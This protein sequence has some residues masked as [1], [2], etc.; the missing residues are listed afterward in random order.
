MSNDIVEHA[1]KKL[2]AE[3]L[4]LQERIRSLRSSRNALSPI[5]R[6]PPEVM[7][8]IFLWYQLLYRGNIEGSGRCAVSLPKWIRVTHV[9]QHWRNIALTSKTLYSTILT[10]HPQYSNE[11]LNRSGSVALS[12][13]DSVNYGEQQLWDT[14]DLQ[15]LVVAA[16]P[17][18]RSLWLDHKSQEFLV[19]HF[20]TSDLTLELEELDLWEW[21]SFIP[22][23][24]SSSLRHLRLRWCPFRSYEWLIRLS[25]LVELRLLGATEGEV[26]AP[27]TL[28]GMLDGMPRLVYLEL[29]SMLSPHNQENRVSS[30]APKLQYLKLYDAPHQLVGLLSWLSFAPRFQIIVSVKPSDRI[31]W[32]MPF[33]EQIGRHLQQSSM[34]LRSANLTWDDERPYKDGEMLFSEDA[35]EEP[36][37][38][39]EV[40]LKTMALFRTCM[41]SAEALPLD[42]LDSLTADVP[43]DLVDWNH[44]QW[45]SL[46]SLR[47]LVLPKERTSIAYLGYLIAAEEEGQL[48]GEYETFASLEELSLHGL[49]YGRDLKSKMQIV[50]AGRMK[51]G[52]KLR[53]LAFYDCNISEDSI[54]QLSKVVD[55][56][57]RHGKK[58]MKKLSRAT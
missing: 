30:I 7:A 16:L 23:M 24:F 14:P 20:K 54:K 11:M 27:D 52:F 5:H 42:D 32:F 33:F 1:R 45:H 6:L 4:V 49:Q 39:L 46:R 50:L 26:V 56:V 41:K 21:N 55:V 2:D 31:D 29:S 36:C 8:Q 38:R 43:W 57:E 51:R 3:I 37:F 34:K 35:E 58:K 44:G 12:F 28:L 22:S 19:P 40:H 13:I 15:E 47:R 17:R 53:K 48:S 9:S 10:H 18:V 25:N